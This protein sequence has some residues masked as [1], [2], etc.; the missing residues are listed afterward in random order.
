QEVCSN[1]WEKSYD[2]AGFQSQ[3]LYPNE[4]LLR[5]C[6]RELFKMDKSERKKVKI[7]EL[8]CGSCSNLWM[9][10]REGFDAYGIDFS[11]KSL[12]LGMIML[13]KWGVTAQLT[14]GSMT[15]L[16][17]EDEYFDV[18]IDIVS[19]YCL[20]ELEFYTCLDE[21]R[22]VLK[23]GG[24]FFSYSP[25]TNSDD[26]KNY[27]PSTKIDAFTLDGIKRKDS[28]YSGNDYSFRFTDPEHYEE[29]LLQR[30]FEVKYLETV[31]RTYKRM[32]ESF[33][34]VTILGKKRTD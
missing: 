25:S 5:F 26:F 30:G 21:T 2:E 7:L 15:Q 16:P 6:G 27:H 28:P 23:K 13:N 29:L 33:E 19:T 11:K 31:T 3:R 22:R 24:I 9:I 20:C 18:V 32:K 34:F 17:Y 12:E 14:A 8:G 1:W 4:E 10:A